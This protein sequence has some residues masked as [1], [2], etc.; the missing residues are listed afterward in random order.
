MNQPRQKHGKNGTEN[1]SIEKHQ[2]HIHVADQIIL[3]NPHGKH[4]VRKRKCQ[5]E[6]NNSEKRIAKKIFR[7]LQ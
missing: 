3:R 1:Q 2:D 4:S 7:K 5:V 6:K